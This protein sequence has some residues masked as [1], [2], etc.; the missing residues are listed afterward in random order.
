MSS[1]SAVSHASTT[2]DVARHRGFW[3]TVPWLMLIVACGHFNRIG[4]SVVGSERIIP[5]RELYGISEDQMGMVYSA[6]L[7]CY[8]LAMIP[9]GWLIDRYGARAALLLWGFGSTV[10][11]GL[12]GSVGFVEA[13]S[14]WGALLVVRGV[15]GVFNAPLHPA[16]ARMVY[17]HVPPESKALANGM[18]TFAACLGIAA[19][20]KVLGGLI[21][22]YDWPKALLMSS[23]LTLVVTAIWGAVTHRSSSGRQAAAHEQHFHWSSLLTVLRHRSVICITLSYGAM[24]YFQYVFFYWI[25]YYFKDVKHH[26]NEVARTYS[27]WITLA[28]GVGMVFGGFLADRVPKSFSPRVRGALVPALA[29]IFSGCAFL[30]GLSA[31][32]PL[33]TLSTF[34]L[35]AAFIGGCEGSFWTTS[36]GL[37]GRYG[38]IVAGLMNCGG[39]AGGTL[40]PWALPLLGS[41][42]TNVT[43][44]KETG[45]NLSL[46][47]AAVIVILGATLWLGVTPRHEQDAPTEPG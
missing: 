22:R 19:T 27:M 25:Q 5:Q 45:W 29:M 10:F 33:I 26:P 12:S 7:L 46:A 30:V 39:N 24:G 28:M 40:S 14:V 43:G 34:A 41:V 8:T 44:N 20:Y 11:V 31:S 15:M 36:V 23:A 16:S 35:A 6:F 18:V 37:G 47:V 17:E 1:A 3:G 38:G 2:P 9:G 13:S 32:H 21:D 4:I 42:F